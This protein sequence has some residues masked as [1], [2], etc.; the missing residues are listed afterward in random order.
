MSKLAW[1]FVVT[2]V[3]AFAQYTV[4]SA[5]APP[6]ELAPAI[7]GVLQKDGMKLTH[8]G[9]TAAEI[10]LRSSMP[11][12]K[13]SEG[14]VSLTNIA[15]GTLIGV[16]RVPERFADR[17]GQTIKPGVYTMR[18]SYFPENG[19][20]QGVAPQRDFVLLAPAA[21]DT[22]PNSTPKF[23]QVVDLS[24]KASGTPHPLVFSVWKVTSDF[25]PGLSQMGDHADWVWQTK[26]GETPIAMI[27]AGKYSE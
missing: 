4:G 14:N 2:A 23:E 3:A 19:D 25:Q 26:L 8:G 13:A 18:L 20:H 1:S 24:R 21:I 7:S 16:M 6:S 9:K 5:G 17:R 22:D 27:L 11:A 10:W 12:G 15:H